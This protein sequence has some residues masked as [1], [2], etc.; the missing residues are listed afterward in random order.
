MQI[1]AR[2]MFQE[3][4]EPNTMQ[5]QWIPYNKRQKSITCPHTAHM[6]SSKHP[7]DLTVQLLQ[8]SYYDILRSQRKDSDIRW[9]SIRCQTLDKNATGKM[10]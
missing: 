9:K 6:V 7:K 2:V 4:L 8:R 1:Y 3:R 10:Y 5:V